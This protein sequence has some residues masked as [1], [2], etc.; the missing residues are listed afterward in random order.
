MAAN[1]FP[2]SWFFDLDGTV[3]DPFV[4]ITNCIRF[5]LTE[6]GAEAPAANDLGWCIGPPLRD[7]FVQLVDEARAD[8]AVE[9]YR[10]RFADVGLFENS[11]YSGIDELL[12]AVNGMGAVCYVASSKPL[13]FVERI[14]ERFELTKYFQQSF[15]SELSGVR[16]DKTELL[17]Y[18]LEQTRADASRSVMI[19]DRK[20]DTIGALNN[21]LRSWGAGWGFGSREELLGAGT[22]IVFDD[23]AELL[24]F[25][26]Q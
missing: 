16:S 13:V 11:K 20:H 7:S 10:Q 6:L 23:V 24:G 14:L 15:G 18:A 8:E 1:R 5:A 2:D 17:A 3:T 21:G 12:N 22:E 26:R 25:V 4:G 9:L 19:G